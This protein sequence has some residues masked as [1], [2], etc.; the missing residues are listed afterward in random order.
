MAATRSSHS[1]VLVIIHYHILY[2][3]YIFFN[4]IVFYVIYIF[5]LKYKLVF[6]YRFS[7]DN[8]IA[9]NI[10]G[11][12]EATLVIT[13][14]DGKYGLN[15]EIENDSNIP[16][17]KLQLITKGK[18]ETRNITVKC[19]GTNELEEPYVTIIT[20]EKTGKFDY[21]STSNSKK[22]ICT[23]ETSFA[24]TDTEKSNVITVKFA[25]DIKEETYRIKFE[26][27]DKYGNKR[28]ENYANFVVVDTPEK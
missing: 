9:G 14:T 3:I 20:L 1:Y 26:L 18:N 17:D 21:T 8:L 4:Y 28:T 27:Y 11:W 10:A 6:E 23:G 13:D 2:L 16:E 7:E 12:S 19:K 15:V 24:T 22:I 25:E 5:K